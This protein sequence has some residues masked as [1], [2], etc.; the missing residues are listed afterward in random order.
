MFWHLAAP[1]GNESQ[2]VTPARW[3]EEYFRRLTPIKQAPES[4]DSGAKSRLSLPKSPGGFVQKRA[5]V[6]RQRDQACRMRLDGRGA[7]PTPTLSCS[8]AATPF[9][10]GLVWPSASTVLPPNPAACLRVGV[11]DKSW[12]KS[13]NYFET[14]CPQFRFCPGDK[15]EQVLG[16][17]TAQNGCQNGRLSSLTPV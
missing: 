8:I 5:L 16:F 17:R 6:A 14:A 13:A 2:R 11:W 3:S 7:F 15:N 12:D 1:L 4:E 9:Q 10:L